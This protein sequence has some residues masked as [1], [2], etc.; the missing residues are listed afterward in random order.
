MNEQLLLSQLPA[1]PVGL[2]RLSAHQLGLLTVR[3]LQHVCQ[4]RTSDMFT[5]FSYH[6][7]EVDTLQ[8]CVPTAS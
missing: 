5:L 2:R 7:S 3:L 6:T 4:Q 1:D 8:T